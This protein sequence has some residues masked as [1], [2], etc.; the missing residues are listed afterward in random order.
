MGSLV[1]ESS[2][3]L[4]TAGFAFTAWKN[5]FRALDALGVGDKSIISRRRGAF[6]FPR[7]PY[8]S[9]VSA[10]GVLPN[11]IASVFSGYFPHHIAEPPGID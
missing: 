1:L 7:Q 6:F 9:N 8:S 4:R 11:A 10:S 5:A 2:P 3:A